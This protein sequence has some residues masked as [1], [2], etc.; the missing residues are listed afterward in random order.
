MDSSPGKSPVEKLYNAI[1]IV[2]AVFIPFSLALALWDRERTRTEMEGWTEF[3]FRARETTEAVRTRMA[4]YEQNLRGAAALFA[5]ADAVTRDD[6]REY[7]RHLQPPQGVPRIVSVA[8]A[9]VIPAARLDEFLAGVRKSDVPEYK[10]SPEG[11][12]PLYVPALYI[13]PFD[14]NLRGLGFDVYSEPVR[15]A[16]L[17]R[18][19]DTGE[20]TLSARI[21][22]AQDAAGGP[23]P[24][25][26]LFVPI[27]RRGTD[28]A[29]LEQR[30]ATIAGFVVGELR[31]SELLQG[32]PAD[33]A[34]LDMRIRDV[35]ADG[36]AAPLAV[37]HSPMPADP[38]SARYRMDTELIINQR[39]WK[40]SFA[41][42]PAFEQ[43]TGSDRP[44]MVLVTSLAL[45]ALV[46]ALIWSLASTRNRA[47]KLAR[48]MTDE[49]RTKQGALAKSEERLSLALQ[50]SGLAI[51]DWNVATDAVQ[52]S[53]QWAAML[54][55]EPQPT[56]TTSKRLSRL[57]HPDDMP[58]L[59]RELRAVLS[60]ESAAY[61]VEHRVRTL[62]G[63]WM[64]VLSRAK[65]AERDAD[66]RARR[67]T[68]TN[69]DV[70]AR[71]VVEKMK[72]EFVG[73]VSH[74]LRTPLTVIVGSLGLLRA[75]L[76][77]LTPDQKM[78]F[79]MACENSARLQ[80]LVNDILDFEKISSGATRFDL[81]PVELAPFLQRS[82]ELNRMYAER[83]KVRY[84]LRHPVPPLAVQADPDRL[85][86]VMANLLS[87]AAKFSPENTAVTVEAI[88]AGEWVR[89][90]VTDCGPGV[91]VEF[92]D[93]I[94]S[95][96]AQADASNTRQQGGTGLGL[97]ICKAIVEKL[98]GR[99]GYESEAGRGA[100]FYFELPA[101][102]KSA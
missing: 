59:Q 47:R 69:S 79:D 78:M 13:E 19:R 85:M 30:R 89:V 31:M 20:A 80:T 92:R 4:G 91:P 97:S 3:E 65:V 100:T 21:I 8:F 32:I 94:F 99:I 10:V 57:V 66:G 72:S 34:A 86:Q 36:S 95:Q 84:E 64:W 41:S 50:G 1:A 9:P 56:T 55:G 88:V 76:T 102:A 98:G 26:A 60:G 24:G 43:R 38:A 45:S 11:S 42:T 15:R 7:Q 90:A 82:I 40:L 6:W 17:N 39:N 96:F 44:Q 61:R 62:R 75:D 77:D 71:K 83:L 29:A 16:A 5:T 53:E 27:Y 93:R 52:L 22:L 58:V 81:Q 51:F 25:V 67:V 28:P 37:K 74:E 23:Q 18:A 68:G 54:G 12:R 63:E 70:T 101:A 46:T 35:S 33:H 73:T 87:N 2:L 49:L 48:G 14:S